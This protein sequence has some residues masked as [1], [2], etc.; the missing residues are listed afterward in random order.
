MSQNTGEPVRSEGNREGSVSSTKPEFRQSKDDLSDKL[1][2][3]LSENDEEKQNNPSGLP[4]IQH[5]SD[6]YTNT[7][8]SDRNEIIKDKSI[9]DSDVRS[10]HFNDKRQL[11]E[12][13]HP[14]EN[15]KGQ[16]SPNTRATPETT[17]DGPEVGRSRSR[18]SLNAA[19]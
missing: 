12:N 6:N 13:G 3:N 19:F 8:I 9:S 17:L 1:Q 18:D 2:S 10:V 16:N 4:A 11:D 15:T 7:S 14:N 5:P